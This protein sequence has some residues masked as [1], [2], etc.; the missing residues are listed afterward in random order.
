MH[1]YVCARLPHLGRALEI[2]IIH[3]RVKDTHKG[4]QQ[5]AGKVWV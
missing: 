4:L 5:A 2:G 3:N 1:I